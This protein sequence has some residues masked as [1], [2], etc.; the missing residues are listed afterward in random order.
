MISPGEKIHVI[1]RRLFETEVRRHFIGEV[2]EREGS[3]VRMQGTVAIFDTSKNQYIKKP[4][5][6]STLFNL[7]ESGY[8]VNIIPSSTELSELQ[9]LT[10]PRGHLVLSDGKEFS[11]DI[12][13]FGSN[14]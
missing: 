9:Y 14:R 4:E 11:L 8:I 3:V 5:K 2:V 6:R 1:Y 13:E 10:N 7:S 12:N